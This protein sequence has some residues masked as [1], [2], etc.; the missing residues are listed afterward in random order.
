M[1]AAYFK[2]ETRSDRT[3]VKLRAVRE[4]FE[5]AVDDI[6]LL[7]VEREQSDGEYCFVRPDR[8]KKR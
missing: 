5:E 8:R 6:D 1:A 7:E 3:T 4:H 2:R